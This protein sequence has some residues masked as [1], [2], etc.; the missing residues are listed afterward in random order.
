MGDAADPVE[1]HCEACENAT[2]P[3]TEEKAAELGAGL[4]A[5]WE[6]T[7]N[8]RLYRYFSFRNFRDAFAYATK[9]AMLAEAEGHH[10]NM[11]I[12]WGRVEL[13][14]VTHSV[15]GLTNNDFV[16]ARMIDRL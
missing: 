16:M 12:G 2:T 3:V 13:T 11:A 9:V 8:E 7:A 1:V 15:G 4:H 10:P 6:R 5:D 14:L